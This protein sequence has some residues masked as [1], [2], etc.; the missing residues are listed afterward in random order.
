MKKASVL[1]ALVMILSL[2][3]CS[4]ASADTITALAT[5]IN[6][7]HL[8]KVASYARILGYN[9]E[10]N[11]LTVE[12]IVPE[13]FS[14]EEVAALK[15]GDGIFTNGQEVLIESIAYDDDWCSTLFINGW[16]I[17]LFEDRDGNYTM[18][19]DED[20]CVWISLGMIECPVQ[21]SL[22]FLDYVDEETGSALTLPVVHTARDLAGRLQE[23]N[24]SEVYTV[25]LSNNN[26][27]V[28]FDE[29][30]QLATIQRFSVPWQ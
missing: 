27:Y 26:V 10:T 6:L 20:D 5:E 9:A 23:E 25:G 14:G 2:L 30:G 8:E 29:A 12:L 4:P 19:A 24:A 28:V 3:L 15:E 11:T 17:F 16:D 22:L 7:D 1:I 21:D 13:R 18:M